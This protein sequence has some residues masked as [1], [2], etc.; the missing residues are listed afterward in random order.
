MSRTFHYILGLVLTIFVL[1]GSTTA[2]SAKID[3]AGWAKLDTH[4]QTLVKQQAAETVV[5]VIVQTHGEETAV[6]SLI[7]QLGGTVTKALPIIDG[8]AAQMPQQA[9]TR[10]AAAPA[11]KHIHFDAPVVSTSHN[12]PSTPIP[13]P[14]AHINNIGVDQVWAKGVDGTG[15]TVA[16]VDS[17]IQGS[18][19]GANSVISWYDVVDGTTADMHGHG[20]FMAGVIGS[21]QKDANNKPIGIAPGVR[22]V[23]VRVLDAQG[24]G[25]YS[26]VLDGLNWVLANRSKTNPRIRVVNLSIAGP[27]TGPYWENP[28]NQAVEQLWKAG[29]VVVTAAGNTGNTP[30]SITTPGNDPFVI[31][32][33]AFTDNYTPTNISDDYIP[34]FSAAGPTEAGFI[35]PDVIAPGAHIPMYAHNTSTWALANVNQTIGTNYFSI[36]GTSP[37]A[38]VTSGVVALML[39]QNPRLTPNLNIG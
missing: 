24:K 32:V 38:A 4:L 37:A 11:I 19:L 33:G 25:S 5:N 9:V 22:L 16:V 34:P 1:M 17:G 36:A 29:L 14:Q 15:I 39:D 18:F 8:F 20:T 6:E 7:Q 28:I 30:G 2:V 12:T 31:T 23:N 26:Q 27:V 3:P 35:K 10:L 21:G 13:N